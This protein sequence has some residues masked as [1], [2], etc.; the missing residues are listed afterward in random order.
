MK[1]NRFFL[2]LFFALGAVFL[3][4]CNKEPGPWTPTVFNTIANGNP[5]LIIPANSTGYCIAADIIIYVDS[6]T[7]YNRSFASACIGNTIGLTDYKD[8]GILKVN[9]IALTKYPNNCYTSNTGDGITD[10]IDFTSGANWLVSYKGFPIGTIPAGPLPSKPIVVSAPTIQLD[11]SY[12]IQ[13]F[14]VTG[15]DTVIYAIGDGYGRFIYKGK[16]K[17]STSC[18]FTKE[19]MATLGAS[20]RG[21]IQVNSY[22]RSVLSPVGTTDNFYFYNNSA[23]VKQNISIQ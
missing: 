16:S 19:E 10:V 4:S 15:G 23:F 14:P 6:L 13:N 7:Q 18:T 1:K 22:K 5:G 17:T 9:G 2:P 8:I 3:F 21:L 20:S 11:T 12:T